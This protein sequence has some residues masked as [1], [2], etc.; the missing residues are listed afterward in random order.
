MS[1]SHQRELRNIIFM[2]TTIVLALLVS[3]SC[4]ISGNVLGIVVSIMLLG[5][6]CVG[7]GYLYCK[8][9]D[10][11]FFATSKYECKATAVKVEKENAEVDSEKCADSE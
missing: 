1:V 7:L 6:L 3:I 11:L 10:K 5:M 8:N 2:A 9:E 4:I